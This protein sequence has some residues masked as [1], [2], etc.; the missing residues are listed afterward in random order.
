MLSVPNT[1]ALGII[2]FFFSFFVVVPVTMCLL[3]F[4]SFLIFVVGLLDFFDMPAYACYLPFD[5]FFP[6]TSTVHCSGHSASTH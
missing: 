3:H 4:V 5:P 2:S 1:E 6:A